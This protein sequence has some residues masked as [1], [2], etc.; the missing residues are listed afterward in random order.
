MGI[1]PVALSSMVELDLGGQVPTFGSGT[2]PPNCS[3]KEFV[4]Y[5]LSRDVI[6]KWIPS[7]T[8]DIDKASFESFLKANEECSSWQPVFEQEI[9][10]VLFGEIRRVLDFFFHPQGSMLFSSYFDF[11]GKGRVGP[12]AAV[13]ARGNSLYAKLFSST[14]TATSSNLYRTYKEFVEWFPFFDE[15]EAHRS[16]EYGDCKLT[17]HSR[18]SFVPKTS[19]SSRMICVEP[20]VNMFCQ[21]GLATLLEERLKSYFNVDLA[22]QPAVNRELARI[23]SLD[24]SFS[25]IDLS[26]ASDR[27]SLNLCKALL[28][29]WVFDTLLELRSPYTR[30]GDT[31]VKLHMLSTMGNGFTFPM[32]TIIFSA[33]IVAAY[34]VLGIPL[35]GT[36][37]CFG[38]DII[39][40]KLAFN[41]VIRCLRMI[42]CKI[43][44][45]KTFN[46]G[47]F[48]E[49]CGADWFYGQPARSVFVKKLSSP[50]DILVA[51][52]SLNAWSAYTG[53]GLYNT[54]QL[55]ISWLPRRFRLP[56]PAEENPDSGICVPSTLLKGLRRDKNASVIYRRFRVSPKSISI[57]DGYIRVPRCVKKLSYNPCGLYVSFLFGELAS[58]RINIRHDN[59][60]YKAKLGVTPRWD[61]IPVDK[62]F[63]GYSLSWQQWETAVINNIDQPL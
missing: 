45:D 14:L 44:S 32:Q 59:L 34:N 23:G 42:G 17:L 36:W 9:D 10:Y 5:H 62:L 33:C 57:G 30:Y 46:E 40:T 3:Y 1:H 48:R 50:H 27:I 56:V 58:F 22:T 24:G 12:G 51:I 39:C 37:S 53:I 52:N 4:S 61:Y 49:S 21:L 18:C 28:P 26:S 38:D 43:N 16:S 11:L 25:T 55:L 7:Q 54:V 63:N 29:S 47:P 19:K 6:R 2:L 20:S 8:D 41:T 60:Y 15:A 13:G 31:S 35:D